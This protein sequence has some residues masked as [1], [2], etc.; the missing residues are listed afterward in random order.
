MVA[1]L[2]VPPAD[3]TAGHLWMHSDGELFWWISHGIV[4]P[5]GAQ[6]M[7]GFGG[8]LGDDQVWAAIDFIRARNAGTAMH[9]N[10]HWTH[11]IQAPGFGAACGERDIKSAD[12]R[13]RFVRLEIGDMEGASAVPGAVTVLAGKRSGAPPGLCVSEDETVPLAYGIVSGMDA[14]QLAG[15]IFLID[16]AGWLRAMQPAG[17]TPSWRNQAALSAEMT[18][19]RA[20]AVAQDTA[21][22]MKMPM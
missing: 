21:A 12:L 9:A 14:A 22:P 1:G 7:P 19:L 10:G 11:T 3:L 4:T 17:A 8:A 20:H 2:P 18:S 15:T 16:E 6:A 5:Q 13:G